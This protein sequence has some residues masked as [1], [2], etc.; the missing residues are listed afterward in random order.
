MAQHPL[1]SLSTEEFRQTAEILRNDGRVTDLWRF[2]SVELK[3]PEKSFVK[4]RRAGD[5]V[6]RTSFAVLLDRGENK[7]YEATV[8]LNTGKVV[9]FEH[10][11]GVQ[12]NFTVDEFYEIDEAMRKHPDVIA[13]LAERGFT[14]MSLYFDRHLGVRQGADAGL[15]WNSPGPFCGERRSTRTAGSAGATCGSGR[16]RRATLRPPG[17][18]PSTGRRHEHP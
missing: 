18:G 17:L 11:P 8:D 5:P 13:A 4:A 3:E 12:P 15:R 2:M 7:T 6:P 9:S 10:I 16:R 14:D 1:D